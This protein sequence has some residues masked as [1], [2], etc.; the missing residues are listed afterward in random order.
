MKNTWKV[1]KQAM[2]ISKKKSNITKISFKN[3]NIEDPKE[4]ANVFNSYFSTIGDN[5]AK[6]IPQPDKHFSRFLGQPNANSIFFSPTTKYEVTDIVTSLNNKQSAGPDDISNFILKGIISSIADPLSH[7]FNK[8][9]LSGIF[10]K[11][12]K[13]A[14]VIPL[15]KKGDVLDTGNYRPISLLSSLSKILERL[16]FIRTTKFLKAHD[17]FTKYQFGFRQKHSTI[18]ALL[19]FVNK[20]AHSI[21]DHSH[22][23]GIFLDFSK[24]F[25]TI[26][27]DILLDKLSYY[28]IRGIALEW[29]RSYLQNRKQ[30]V[31][32]NDHISSLKE[33]NCGVPQGSILGPL[34]FIVYINDFHRSSDILSFILFADDTNVFF[35]HR[36]LLTLVRIINLELKKLTQWIRANKLSLNLQKTKY[37][38]FSNTIEALPSDII[39]DDSPL[40][41]VSQIKF[42]GITVDNKLSWKPH[43]LNVCK[44][45]SR[46]IG[47]INKLKYQFPSTTLFTLYSSLILPYLNYG[48]LAWGNTHISLLDKILILQKKILRIICNAPIRSHTDSLFLE[49]KILKIKDLYLFQL[50]QF[51][52]KYNNNSLPRI[53]DSMFPQN[54]SFHNY[55][56]RRSNEFHL[57]LLRT[58]L[59]Q[60]TFLYTGPRFWNSLDNEIKV[61]RSLPSFKN[62]LKYMLLNRNG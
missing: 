60:N 7:I 14:K 6:N 1:I 45:L 32:L 35:A 23:I 22:L 20:V 4:I 33:I 46:N 28:G 29:F 8:S 16:I 51:M 36:N 54:Q 30:Y 37:M 34:L 52:F 56:T 44:T 38:I 10:P 5:L 2:N 57:P 62:K 43:V 40:E 17:T 61:A 41:C 11:Q 25:D 27:H 59:A 49:H 9:I 12:L 48:I 39:F 24:A 18:H 50:G 13:I 55:P 53:F 19:S 26:N 21:D 47:I 3:R 31:Y 58:L 15:Y 42:L